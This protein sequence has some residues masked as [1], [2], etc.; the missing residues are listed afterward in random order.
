MVMRKKLN[1]MIKGEAFKMRDIAPGPTIALMS[2]PAV[3]LIVVAVIVIFAIV[4]IVKIS[5]N[6]KS[7][8][9]PEFTGIES[10]TPEEKDG[11][12]EEE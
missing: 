8:Y 6:K 9:S 12:R 1:E 2:I 3:L 7:L 5:K 10:E 11:K 4:K